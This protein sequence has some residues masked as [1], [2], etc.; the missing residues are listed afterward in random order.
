MRALIA[1]DLTLANE[2]FL[3]IGDTSLFTTGE[4]AQPDQAYHQNGGQL[5]IQDP[6]F[7]TFLKFSSTRTFQ[8]ESRNG[9]GLKNLD[10][11]HLN[12]CEDIIP[13]CDLCILP[14]TSM[15]AGG[16][17]HGKMQAQSITRFSHFKS[18]AETQFNQALTPTS[19]HLSPA[20]LECKTHPI[21]TYK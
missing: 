19:W 13:V 15:H 2:S 6:C 10:L 8:P 14:G 11:A 21:L 1:N 12:D 17:S 18:T 7:S 5:H 20:R 4:G 16:V 9:E 3:A